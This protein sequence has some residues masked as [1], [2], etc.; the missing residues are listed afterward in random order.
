MAIKAKDLSK[1]SGATR[2]T[3]DMDGFLEILRRGFNFSAG[4]TTE[5]TFEDWEAAVDAID[6]D[7]GVGVAPP[8]GSEMFADVELPDGDSRFTG[9]GIWT[10][11]AL[12]YM[13]G[14]CAFGRGVSKTAR[15]FRTMQIRDVNVPTGVGEALEMH[16]RN[17]F[18]D[19]LADR[20]AG[21]ERTPEWVKFALREPLRRSAEE[22]RD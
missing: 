4:N 22:R 19:A 17:G 11:F 8:V 12:A 18:D 21:G 5:W 6:D 13:R 14:R 7:D 15:P 10:L 3:Q 2:P 9:H 20:V 1:A 16:F